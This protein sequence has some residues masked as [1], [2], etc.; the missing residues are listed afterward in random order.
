MHAL[1][2]CP[3][4]N[5]GVLVCRPPPAA[6]RCPRRRYDARPPLRPEELPRDPDD[7]FGYR[8]EE[9]AAD[10]LVRVSAGPA[11]VPPPLTGLFEAFFGL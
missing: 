10:R 9:E 1:L 4:D 8:R 11:A 2:Q 7:F 3:L 5:M 6:V